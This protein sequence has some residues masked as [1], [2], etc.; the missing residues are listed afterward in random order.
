M[1]VYKIVPYWKCNFPLIPT[2][3]H[4]FLQNGG[5]LHFHAPLGAYINFVLLVQVDTLC[6]RA[7]TQLIREGNTR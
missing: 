1:V 2:V 3:N 4:N 6:A 5:K 7:T